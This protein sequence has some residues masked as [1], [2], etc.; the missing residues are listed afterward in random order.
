MADRKYLAVLSILIIGSLCLTFAAPSGAKRIIKVFKVK[1]AVS[2]QR[3]ADGT[4]TVKAV[5]T[6]Q[7]PICFSKKMVR[8]LSEGY[9]HNVGGALYYT[10]ADGYGSPPDHGWLSPVS[11]PSR[12]RWIWKAVWPGDTRV[13]PESHNPGLP[14]PY[15]TTVSAATRLHLG[16]G[17]PGGKIKFRRNGVKIKLLCGG[18]EINKDV[19][20]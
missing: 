12:T 17:P 15:R 8:R 11:R 2:V 10:E 7:H 19:T 18:P 1:S 20:F 5:C 3:T 13:Y 14:Y 6:T 4:I 16:G 9:F